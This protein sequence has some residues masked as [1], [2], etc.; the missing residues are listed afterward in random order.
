VPFSIRD[1]Y[2]A[3][4]EYRKAQL[5]CHTTE[6][7][8]RL[9]PVE[10]LERYRAAGYSFV[11]ITD[12]NRVTRETALDSSTFASIPGTEDTVARWIKPLG[13]HMT[14]LFVESSLNSG[15]A[16]DRIDRTNASG[17]IVG[18]SHPSWTGNLWTGAWSP[19]AITSLRG[20]RLFEI[21]NPHSPP[22]EDLRR[23][24]L[25]LSAHGPDPRHAIWGVAV[26]DCHRLQ[27]FNRAWIVAKV[28]TITAEALRDA[29][30]WGAFYASTGLEIE[31][32]FRTGVIWVHVNEPASIQFFDSSRATLAAFN[33]TSASY[34]VQGVEGYVRIECGSGG[35]RAWSQPFWIRQ[36]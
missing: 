28:T 14:R 23:W 5:H 18:L 19:E 3:P 4:G 30:R 24:D 1:P 25:A 2:A 36:T 33:G 17:G 15:Q 12:H 21:W 26:D 27:Q 34:G 22:E 10:L 20:F 9:S 31:C 8:G 32:G 7:D 13:P 35:R 11:S 6:S 16:Q 29:L